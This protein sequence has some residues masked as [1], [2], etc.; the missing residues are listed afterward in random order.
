MVTLSRNLAPRS[1]IA[2]ITSATINTLKDKV[3]RLS[4]D[5]PT[6]SILFVTPSPFAHGSF[7]VHVSRHST[8]DTI[9]DHALEKAIKAAIAHKTAYPGSRLSIFK[10]KPAPVTDELLLAALQR[11]VETGD[12]AP[13]QYKLLLET[14]ETIKKELE[15]KALKR[16]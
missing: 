6:C 9:W 8:G 2:R 11:R 4:K 3:A 14:V 5:Y 7:R 16:E 12:V 10:H 13:K 1:G 15:Q